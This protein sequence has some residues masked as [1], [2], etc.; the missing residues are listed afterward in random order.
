MCRYNVPDVSYGSDGHTQST[1]ARANSEAEI[2]DGKIERDVLTESMSTHRRDIQLVRNRLSQS[3]V[4]I[5]IHL[6]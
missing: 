1:E 2:N 3:N 4:G 5:C 6:G